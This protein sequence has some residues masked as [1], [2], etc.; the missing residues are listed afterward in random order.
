MKKIETKVGL[1]CI[2]RTKRVKLEQEMYCAKSYDDMGILRGIHWR[3]VIK[4]NMIKRRAEGKLIKRQRYKE[5]VLSKS[6][7]RK[8]RKGFTGPET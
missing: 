4:G 2:R 7:S 5:R 1:K 6:N 8:N 3:M